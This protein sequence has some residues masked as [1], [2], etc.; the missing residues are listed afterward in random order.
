M[1]KIAWPCSF[2]KRKQNIKS[3][4]LVVLLLE[5]TPQVNFLFFQALFV[6]SF[7]FT[8]LRG[9]SVQLKMVSFL[10]FYFLENFQTY[11]PTCS[12]SSAPRSRD[13]EQSDL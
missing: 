1:E 13:F 12:L 11:C 5:L 2:G 8:Q 9:V 7:Q 3:V 4:Y 10:K 6:S